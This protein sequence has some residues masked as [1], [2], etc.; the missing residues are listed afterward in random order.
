MSAV[1]AL[2]PALFAQS[3]PAPPTELQ[4]LISL[5]QPYVAAPDAARIILH[6]HNSTAK[7]LWL[8][9]R[10]KGKRAA[11]DD[12]FAPQIAGSTVEIK[13]TPLEAAGSTTLTPAK[14]IV[15][16]YAQMPKPRLAKV[17][18]GADY[19]ETSIVQL[20]PALADGDKPVWGN[21]KFQV[22]YAASYPNHDVFKNALDANLWQGDIASNTIPIELRPP[23]PDATGEISGT[24]VGTDNQPRLGVRVSLSDN[25]GQLIDQRVTANDGRFRFD[26]LPMATYWITGR[27][28]GAKD[29]STNF[30]HQELASSLPKADIQLMMLPLESE[31]PKKFVHK[32]VLI[33][34]FDSSH[35]PLSGVAIDT[36]YGGGSLIDDLKAET[37]ADGTAAMELLPGHVAVSLKMHGCPEQVERAEVSPEMGV[38]GFR[39]I[40]DCQKK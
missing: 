5:K 16:E 26:H 24:A 33:R 17:A 3:E 40:F 6:L 18:A 7:P 19:E 10:A 34:V 21:Y 11:S 15:L 9:R 27:Y 37:D 23:L 39:Y 29:D 14:A 8:Y 12:P 20:Q 13:L 36:V 35:Q 22:T 2:A 32:P 25:D 31:D 1:C 30:T 28:E 38:E 4:L